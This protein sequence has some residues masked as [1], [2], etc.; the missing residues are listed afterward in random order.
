M[1]RCSIASEIL[2]LLVSTL[3][4]I[5]IIPM[6]IR[7]ST[8]S[9]YDM[10]TSSDI[11]AHKYDSWYDKHSKVFDSE[12]AAIKKVLGHVHPQSRSIEIGVGTG[13]FAQALYII[14]GAD[15][16]REMLELARERNIICTQAVAESLPF[17]DTSF[18]LAMMVTVD[19][20]LDELK[21]A[22]SEVYRILE[23]GGRL[24]LGMIDR[25]SELGTMYGKKY[26]GKHHKNGLDTCMRLHSFEEISAC[27]H[28]AGFIDITTVQTLFRPLEMITDVEPVKSGCGDGGFVVIRA[29]K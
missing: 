15:P 2:M 10:R 23:P 19:C 20:F 16:S 14:H 6:A 4:F 7:T 5:F 22:F 17:K 24:V 12:L 8:R 3:I 27:I 25:N 18:D 29:D 11:H 1:D 9:V 28:E 26:E 21:Q 13:R